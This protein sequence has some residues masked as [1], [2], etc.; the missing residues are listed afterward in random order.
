MSVS[1]LL[2]FTL[3]AVLAAPHCVGMCGCVLAKPWMERHNAAFQLG[4][5]SAYGLLGAVAGGL[6]AQVFGWAV[7]GVV[8]F[9]AI[10][11]MLM[12]ALLF[13][14]VLLIVRSRPLIAD[15]VAVQWTGRW[16]TLNHT[17]GR[18]RLSFQAGLMWLVMP[19]GLLYTALA[20]AYLSGSVWAGAAQM[21]WFGAL[22]AGTLTLT[23]SLQH[24]IRQ[25]LSEAWLFRIN[26]L[27]LLFSLVLMQGQ[28]WGLIHTPAALQGMGFCL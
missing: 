6:S 8:L 11:A 2:S 3:L 13:V 7:Q 27:M 18:A 25:W 1:V 5:V 28:A 4:R 15:A 9:Q 16:A 14:A 20:L 23:Q 21:A 19:C 24:H 22:T 17:R 10:H 26:G 12:V